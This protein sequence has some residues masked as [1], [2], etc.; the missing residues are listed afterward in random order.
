MRFTVRLL[1]KERK[2]L[3]NVELPKLHSRLLVITLK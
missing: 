1:V 2:I 3:N